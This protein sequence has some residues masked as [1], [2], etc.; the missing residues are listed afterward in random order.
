M[1]NKTLNFKFQISNLYRLN[2]LL[3]LLI[4]V[5]AF[6]CAK[7]EEPP[8]IY[9]KSYFPAFPGSYWIYTNGETKTV[10]PDYC[11]HSYQ[12]GIV[13][14]DF[15]D[16]AYVPRIGQ[17]YV[18][19]YSIT[20]NSTTYPLKKLLSEKFDDSWVV[21]DWDGN[22]IKR[23]VV[24]VDDTINI[25]QYPY[26]NDS[27]TVYSPVIEV[28]EFSSNEGDTLWFSKEYYAKNIGLIRRDINISHDS[29]NAV[30]EFELVKCLINHEF[31]K[32]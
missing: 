8:F 9:P 28:I 4:S 15:S 11:L 12:Q 25:D 18:Y 1:K 31:D 22:E 17:Q 29:I 30:V 27:V 26:I 2:I 3:L 7:D 20:Q 5:L 16:D 6:S 13:S 10:A 32:K 21:N 24:S 14:P 23:K 19:E